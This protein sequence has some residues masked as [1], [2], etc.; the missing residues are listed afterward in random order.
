MNIQFKEFTPV[1]TKDYPV[2]IKEIGAVD[3]GQFGPQLKWLFDL[4]DVE[5]VDGEVEPKTL[6]AWSSQTLSAKSK[7]YQWATAA[8]WEASDML[9]IEDLIGKRVLISVTLEKRTDGTVG[10]KVNGVLP[11]RRK[12]TTN[13]HSAPQQPAKA[14]AAVAADDADD[15]G[16]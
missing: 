10:N 1:P 15:L 7:L 2:E 14:A 8:G 13:G 5:N 4:G 6:T 11:I 12:A 9:T 3:D 16:F